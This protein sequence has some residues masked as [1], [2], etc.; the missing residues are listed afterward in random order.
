MSLEGREISVPVTLQPAGPLFGLAPL[1]EALGAELSSDESGESV[2][3]RIGDTEVVMGLGS[4]IVTVGD[5]IV[6]LSQPPVPGEGGVQVPVE[7]LRKSFGDLLG[8]DFEWRPEVA[9]L[10]VSRRGQRDMRVAVDVVHLQGVTTV[11]LHFSETP[12]YKVYRHPGALDVQMVADRV[13][14]PLPPPVIQDP[15]VQ[16]VAVDPQLI[17]ISFAAGAEVDSYVLESPFRLVFDVHRA[18]SVVTA[19]ARPLALRPEGWFGV[20]TIVLD[21]GHGGKETGAIGPSGV[22]EKELTLELARE[23]KSRLEQRLP[24]RVV[25]T[26]DSD[27]EVAHDTRTAI[28]NQNQADLFISIHLNSSLGAGAHGAETYFLSTEASDARAAQAA[29]AENLGVE[30]VEGTAVPEDTAA[31]DLQLILWDLAQTHHLVESQRLAT[32]IQGELNET[33]QL[34]DRGVKQ[35]PFRVLMGATMPAVLV[36][37]GFVSNLEEEKK[38]QEASYRL[39][40]VEALA[41]AVGRYKAVA[42]NRDQ[43]PGDAPGAPAAPGRRPVSPP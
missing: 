37:V 17:R 21:P 6:S 13:T 16:S 24:V 31:Q 25:L 38:L 1:A 20:R 29:A 12:R 39:D 3:L 41:R 8:Y 14:P 27:V 32:I 40:L 30:A 11:V 36:E 4:A 34:K 19:P 15:L 9:R 22:Q 43:P 23:L 28:A 10:I 26:R 42:E 7:L 18:S 5:A 33:L 35:A 2:T